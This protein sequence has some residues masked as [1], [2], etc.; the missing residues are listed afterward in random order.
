MC[1]RSLTL[2][3]FLSGTYN[4][5]CYDCATI[6]DYDCTNVRECPYEVRR[7]LT[8]SIR[9][10]LLVFL[11]TCELVTHLGGFRGWGQSVLFSAPTHGL[12]LALSPS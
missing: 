9:K 11:A 10:Y 7:C 3:S 8:V 1:F 5:K 6:N 2:L 4:L 12:W